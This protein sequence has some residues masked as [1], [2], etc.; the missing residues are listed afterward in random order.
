MDIIL[1]TIGGHYKLYYLIFIMKKIIALGLALSPTLAFAQS[2]ISDLN[3][4]TD[5]AVSIGNTAVQILISL[6]VIWIIYSVVRYMVIGASSEE[7]RTAA[8]QSVIYGVIG[9]FIILSIWGLVAI[10][11]NTFRTQDQIPQNQIDNIVKPIKI[12]RVI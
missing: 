12:D 11:R 3:S 6:A 4:A 10:L 2:Q 7:A 8:R 5:K 9:L 1:D